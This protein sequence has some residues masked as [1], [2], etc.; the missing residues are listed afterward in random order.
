MRTLGGLALSASKSWVVSSVL[1][2][3]SK[4]P[5]AQLFVNLTKPNFSSSNNQPTP[6][7]RI[8]PTPPFIEI[9]AR[10]QHHG[11]PPTPSQT[12]SQTTSQSNT[13]PGQWLRRT[14]SSL[15]TAT[16]THDHPHSSRWCDSGLDAPSRG[17]ADSRVGRRD[18]V[19]MLRP[20]F[21]IGW[22]SSTLVPF[23]IPNIRCTAPTTVTQRGVRLLF[24]VAHTGH[25]L[26][27]CD[28]GITRTEAQRQNQC[29][30]HRGIS[31][32]DLKWPGRVLRAA[33]CYHKGRGN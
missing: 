1:G 6:L 22:Y 31:D 32:S 13:H 29:Y 4:P 23:T 18:F 24:Q 33:C 26:R 19:S 20:T 21:V 3:R 16:A 2:R 10:T 25:S 27:G 5:H 12:T 9:P 17:L 30:S 7:L 8:G 11:P 15:R 28:S 14:L